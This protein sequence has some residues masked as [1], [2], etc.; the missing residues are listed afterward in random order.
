MQVQQRLLNW[1]E[2][3]SS[4]LQ[5]PHQLQLVRYEDMQQQPQQTFSDIATF[6]GFTKSQD[7]IA[8]AVA[9]C[10]FDKLKQH[11]QQHGFRER[12]TAAASFFRRG[13]VGDGR[14]ELSAAQQQQLYQ[15]H[16]LM[17]DQLGYTR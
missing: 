9:A 5:S 13:K 14:Q 6:L 16:A 11:E 3:V 12:P 10:Q 8:A 1:S 7:E 15:C 4:W 2:H 17:M